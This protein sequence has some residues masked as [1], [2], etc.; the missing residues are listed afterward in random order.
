MKGKHNTAYYWAFILPSVIAISII[1][2]IP[3]LLGIGTSLTNSDGYQAVFTG[4]ENYQ[5]LFKD[6]QFISSMWFTLRFS[7]VA[8]ILINAIGLGLALLVTQKLGKVSTIFRTIF[9]MPNLIGGIILGFIWQF[10]FV[11]AFEGIASA[12][13]ISFFS[14]WLSDSTTGFWALVIVFLWQMSGY[15]MIVYISFLAN[16]PGELLEAGQMDGANNWQAFWK[17]KFPMLAPAFTISLFLTLANAFKVYDVNLALTNGAPYGSTEMVAMNIY[18]TA[19]YQYEQGYAQAKAIVFLLLIA[20]ISLTQI[21]LTRR[22]EV[23]L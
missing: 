23:D 11:R 14:S 9:F 22:K 6:E 10:I 15:I 18:N 19:F 16:I 7:F 5:R 8:V 20:A 4:L 1:I 17:I 3:L 2:L 12:T 13:G 21:F